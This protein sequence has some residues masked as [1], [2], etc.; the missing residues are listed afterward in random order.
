LYVLDNT[1][2]LFG[3]AKGVI[4]DLVKQFAGGGLH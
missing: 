3:D 2:M 1:W 4:G